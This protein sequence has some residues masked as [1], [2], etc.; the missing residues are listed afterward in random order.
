MLIRI[1]SLS[2]LTTVL[3]PSLPVQAQSCIPIKIDGRDSNQ[4]TNTI[5]PP[6]TLVS[7]DNWDTN[8]S[9]PSEK[10]FR[11]FFLTFI[12]RDSAE[13]DVEV[14]LVYQDNTREQFYY[15]DA[16]QL[17]AGQNLPVL[18]APSSGQAPSQVSLVVGGLQAI[19][20]TYTASVVGCE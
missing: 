3:I 1:A 9:I 6:G 17:I 16:L 13:Y 14:N 7:G 20:N 15:Q 10:S 11:R 5:S 2:I 18:I 8:W 19:G 4:V 12:P